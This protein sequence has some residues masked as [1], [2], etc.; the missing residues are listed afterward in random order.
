MLETLF[1]NL[2]R[3]Y[4]TNILDEEE[5]IVKKTFLDVSLENHMF[6]QGKQTLMKLICNHFDQKK[7]RAS[8]IV[9]PKSL[10]LHKSDKYQKMIYIL[11]EFHDDNVDCNIEHFGIKSGDIITLVEDYLYELM[12][13]TD[14]F[15]DFYFEIPTYNDKKYPDEYEP[16]QSDLRLNNL[17]IK[18][19]NCLQYDTR[20]DI[21]CK[22]ARTHY[23][24]IRTHSLLPETNDFLWFTEQLH[25][26]TILYDLEEQN[27]FCQT[28][29]VDERTMRV[30]TIL[31]EKDIT[32]MVDFLKTNILEENRF[33]EKEM[34]KIKD[35]YIKQMIDEFTYEELMDEI[36]IE[37][38]PI[39]S[40]AQNIL[41]LDKMSLYLSTMFMGLRNS[42]I[43]IKALIPDK[44]LLAR[45]FKNFD[46]KELET[47][48]YIGA[49]DQPEKAHNI[50]IYAGNIHAQ[51]YRKFLETK[52]G[53][54]PLEKTGILE[55]D[56][57]FDVDQKGNKN[58]IDMTSITQPLFSI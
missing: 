31:A 36:Q 10:T 51:T 6:N 19:R 4:N 56:R 35:P 16:Y 50:I 42:L 44:Y 52:L 25:Q 8:F 55:E 53:F 46:L 41:K 37:L 57:N 21:D 54:T 18:F 22:L 49:T 43:Y 47:K 5:E 17:F 2:G 27:L 15:I 3:T 33:I 45:L 24:D 40:F 38:S 39:Q 12:L 23:F 26:L 32:K 34:K 28:L 13:T 14:V 7:P 9:G 29:L 58:C 1:E 20:M 48:G 30:V 11:G